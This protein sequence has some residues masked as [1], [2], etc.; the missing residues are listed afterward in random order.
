MILS[1]M[2][3]VTY[4]PVWC[5]KFNQTWMNILISKVV[6]VSEVHERTANSDISVNHL[7]FN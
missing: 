7:N 5:F 3:Q 1:Q 6:S 2:K 4:R